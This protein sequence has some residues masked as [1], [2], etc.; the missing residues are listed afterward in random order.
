MGK[1]KLFP[2]AEYSSKQPS[3]PVVFLV[4]RTGIF[5]GPSKSGKTV[6]LISMILEQH[7]GVF[8]KIYIYIDDSWVPVKKHIEEDLGVNTEREQAYYDEWDEAAL[9]GIIQRQRKITKT[10]K[11]LEM[12]KLYQVLIILF[13]RGRHLQIS[14]SQKLRLISAAVRVNMQFLCCW[15]LR[16]QHE[17]DA[18]IEELS[19]LLPK[20]KLHRIYEQATR[21][22]YSLP[23]AKESNVPHALRRAFCTGK[24]SRWESGR[25]AARPRWPPA[26]ACPARSL[27]GSL[28]T[29]R[30]LVRRCSRPAARP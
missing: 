28:P 9:R 15:R 7:R 21:E 6:A 30:L 29:A 4:P 5:L 3:D 12:K 26:S 14:T 17:L 1:I 10:S 20:D 22:P 13:I 2:T 19:A 24:R 25:P 27:C 23:Q 11:K 8:E 18:V 16:D